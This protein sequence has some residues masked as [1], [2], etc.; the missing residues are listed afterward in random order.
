MGAGEGKTRVSPS[1][2]PVLSCPPYFLTVS[3][4]AMLTEH[5]IDKAEVTG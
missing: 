3:K 1:R 4:Q 5:R 2:T